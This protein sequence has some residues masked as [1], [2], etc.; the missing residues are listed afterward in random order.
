MNNKAWY[1][2]KEMAEVTGYSVGHIYNIYNKI[3]HFNG[4][5]PDQGLNK[6]LAWPVSEVNKMIM[7]QRAT[8]KG[9]GNVHD[10]KN[11]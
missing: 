2:T 10:E 8:M 11:G 9:A 1:T 3:K 5:I 6:R 4:I 7:R